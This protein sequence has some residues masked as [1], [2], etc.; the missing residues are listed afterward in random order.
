MK[1]LDILLNTLTPLDTQDVH[2]LYS[3]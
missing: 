3:N 2:A 1:R